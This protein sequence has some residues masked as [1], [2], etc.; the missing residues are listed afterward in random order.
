MRPSPPKSLPVL[1]ACAMLAMP[2][3]AS[4]TGGEAIPVTTVAETGQA[5]Q[6]AAQ[7][8][9]VPRIGQALDSESLDALRG[10]EASIDTHV[11]NGGEVD[12][13][14]ADGVTSGANFIGEGAFNDVNGISTVIQNSGSNVLIQNG[15]A[16]NVQFVDPLP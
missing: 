12:G 16:V 5:Q 3:M 10:G 2:A 14:T 15:T 8:R 9:L 7:P 6:P 4:A 1:V 11:H 13:N